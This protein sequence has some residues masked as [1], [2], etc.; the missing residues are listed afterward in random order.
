[1]ADPNRS[2]RICANL[3]IASRADRE[4]ETA[5]FAPPVATL[6]TTP[7][8]ALLP[9]E[10]QCLLVSTRQCSDMLEW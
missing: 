1:M 5:P 2:H 6:M 4:G 10:T 7:Q 3:R 8:K 9:C